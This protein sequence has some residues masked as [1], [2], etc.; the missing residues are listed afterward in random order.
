MKIKV[1]IDVFIFNV[2]KL[3]IILN[4]MDFEICI[5]CNRTELRIHIAKII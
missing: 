3:Y 2:F 4:D 5:I 1:G